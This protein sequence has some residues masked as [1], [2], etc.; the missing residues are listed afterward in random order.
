MASDW[1]KLT[2]VA[3]FNRNDIMLDAPPI[4][5][6]VFPGNG[7]NDTLADKARKLGVPLFDFSK[8]GT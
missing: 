4:R 3:P 8:G 1:S 5:V 2:K 7:I 6:I